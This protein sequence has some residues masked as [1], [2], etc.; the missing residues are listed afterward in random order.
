MNNLLSNAVKFTDQGEVVVS[1]NLVDQDED[2]FYVQVTVLDTGIG[3]E[4]DKIDV[5]FD[6]FRQANE[7]ITRKYCPVLGV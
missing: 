1:L 2:K 6:K 5:I 4:Q 3:I 7:S